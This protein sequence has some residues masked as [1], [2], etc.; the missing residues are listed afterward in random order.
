MAPQ[1]DDDTLHDSASFQEVFRNPLKA[2]A[3]SPEANWHCALD[4]RVHSS[5]EKIGARSQE[6]ESSSIYDVL[7]ARKHRGRQCPVH[8]QRT[9]K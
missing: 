4:A 1:T 3:T 2:A 9:K 5:F 8:V 7:T 6:K